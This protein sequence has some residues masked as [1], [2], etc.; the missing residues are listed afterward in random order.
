MQDLLLAGD[1]AGMQHLSPAPMRVMVI[2]NGKV[3]SSLGG[4]DVSRHHSAVSAS[5]FVL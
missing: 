5:R 1:V 2:A 3:G 4:A